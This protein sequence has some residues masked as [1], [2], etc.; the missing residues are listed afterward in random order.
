MQ[1]LL[2]AGQALGTGVPAEESRSLHS[3]NSRMVEGTDKSQTQ[4]RAAKKSAIRGLESTSEAGF[5]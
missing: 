2:H 1:H 3:W 4:V 5:R